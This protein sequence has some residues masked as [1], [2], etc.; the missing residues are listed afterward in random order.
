MSGQSFVLTYLQACTSGKLPFSECGPVWQL[1]V[2]AMFLVL[3]V[4]ALLVLRVR[5]RAQA[6]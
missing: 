6:S 1:A 3:A 2:I 4:A 5:G